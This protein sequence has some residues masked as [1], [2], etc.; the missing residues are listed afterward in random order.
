MVGV[1][2]TIDTNG[3]YRIATN[4][5]AS[6][7]VDV[8][9]LER[10]NPPALKQQS[11]NGYGLIPVFY[12]DWEE[13]RERSDQTVRVM[14]AGDTKDL[15]YLRQEDDSYSMR[16][17]ALIKEMDKLLAISDAEFLRY[18]PLERSNLV[19]RF[20]AVDYSADTPILADHQ[21]QKAENANR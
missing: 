2:S 6:I 9:R 1:L 13:Q 4:W 7:Q 21:S 19:A 17:A 20:A 5:L 11:I 10:E 14:I 8:A 3:A 16:P 18:S 15:L 12:V